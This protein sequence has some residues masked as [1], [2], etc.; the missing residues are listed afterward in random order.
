MKLSYHTLRKEANR[1][2][3]SLD[4]VT[5]VIEG[6][7]VLGPPQDIQEVKIAYEAYEQAMKL[8]PYSI[9][10]LLKAHKIMMSGLE[11]EAGVFRS[12]NVGVYAGS[13]LI[14][15][16]TPANYVTDLMNQLFGW[17]KK[18]KYHPLVKSCL[19]H[20]EF[21]FIHPFADGNGRTG[22]LWQTLILTKWKEFFAW[23][24]VETLVHENHYYSIPYYTDRISQ[25]SQ[26]IGI[27]PKFKEHLARYGNF[28]K[29]KNRIKKSIGVMDFPSD[30]DAMVKSYRNDKYLIDSYY[31]WFYYSFDQLDNPDPFM[32]VQE[33]VENIYTNTWLQRTVPKWNQPLTQEAYDRLG[34]VRQERF[35][36]HY[37]RPYDGKERVIVIIS[38][39]FRNECAMELMR[40]F[41]F[42]EK[43]T[44][45]M[46]VLLSC[47]PS[48]TAVGMASLLPHKEMTVDEKL[49]V[50]I[51]GMPCN[52]IEN[53][54][55]ILK[56][57]NEKNAAIRFDSVYKKSKAKIREQL[58]GKNIVYIYHNQVDAR[59]DKPASENEVF[60]ACAEAISEIFDLIKSL[61]DAVSATRFIVTAD[62][63]FLYKRGKLKESDKVQIN[64]RSICTYEN[65]RFL[66]TPEPV[67]VDKE[68]KQS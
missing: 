21:G 17:L 28:W 11:K 62:H 55:K 30:I 20:Y 1:K 6:K 26:E 12:G 25:M 67:Q 38:D 48:V 50:R 47:L 59:G 60:N 49:N 27:D 61:T 32:P 8:D 13:Q 45:K 43:C 56:L 5:D 63:G 46:D 18:T 58:Q 4:Q 10:D 14:H 42:D 37:L 31:R 64:D 24:P 57:K 22:R 34:L 3:L 36:D 16:G 66:I 9:R 53:R 52:G 23:L 39:A 15:A 2:S 65:K 41:E 7:R 29:N 44:A 35:F 51:D 54:D 19:F 40:R 33:R 68:A